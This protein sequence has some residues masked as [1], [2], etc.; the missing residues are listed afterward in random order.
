MRRLCVCF[1]VL[2]FHRYL[3]QTRMQQM[4]D[5]MHVDSTWS[6]AS[7]MYTYL[8]FVCAILFW[9]R[10]LVLVLFYFL[11]RMLIAFIS[12][13]EKHKLLAFFSV[14][15]VATHWHTLVYFCVVFFSSSSFCDNSIKKR[16]N[17]PM[18]GMH[19]AHTHK[20]NKY[21]STENEDKQQYKINFKNWKINRHKPFDL[22][23]WCS[24]I[25]C[26]ALC[27]I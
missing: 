13:F 6:V 27:R 20:I 22:F 7:G 17:R 12:F 26:H 3:Q 10:C 4:F 24:I 14:Y 21:W 9:L 15:P 16:M 5:T 8:H 23:T 11:I 25:Y 19:S 2:V 1:Y 18:Y